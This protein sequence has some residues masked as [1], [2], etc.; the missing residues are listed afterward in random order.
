MSPYFYV[1]S[2]IYLSVKP[3]LMTR[4]AQACR[5]YVQYGIDMCE[6]SAYTASHSA[7]AA[8]A[9]SDKYLGVL[10]TAFV[11]AGVALR[12]PNMLSLLNLAQVVLYQT[13]TLPGFSTALEAVTR[14]AALFFDN[15]Q[16]YF[17]LISQRHYQ[18]WSGLPSSTQGLTG[19]FANPA[20]DLDLT[21]N[22]D[23]EDLL[24]F[25]ADVIEFTEQDKALLVDATLDAWALAGGQVFLSV[26]E[27]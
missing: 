17:S 12:L 24:A 25:C 15:L 2:N 1:Q 23:C 11:W 9:K 19:M 20:A 21:T 3:S 22:T 4:L 5:S 10:F 26:L 6:L 13:V 27:L 7:T 14:L 18:A 8:L 16:G